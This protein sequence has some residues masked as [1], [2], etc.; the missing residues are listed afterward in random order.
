VQL[1]THAVAKIVPN[2]RECL[3]IPN[4]AYIPKSS[5]AVLGLFT[6]FAVRQL[7]VGYGRS[8]PPDRVHA[9]A[10]NAKLLEE[11]EVSPQLIGE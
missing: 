3:C 9:A 2:D 5:L 11:F 4:I 1:A 10:V 8:F 6:A 7:F